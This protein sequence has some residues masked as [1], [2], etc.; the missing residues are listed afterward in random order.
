M[1]EA[2][3]GKNITH[4]QKLLNEQELR[5]FRS[6]FGIPISDK[7]ID[8]I[9]FYKPDENSTEMQYLR[10]RREKLNGSMPKR[11][12]TSVVVQPPKE[13]LFQEFLDGTKDREVSTTMAFVRILN[14]LLQHQEI[15]KTVVPIVPDEARTFGM[16]ALFRQVGIYSHTGQLYE[17]VDKENLLYYKEAKDGQILEEGITEAGSMSSFI[18]A[19]TAYSTH[20][21]NTI[22]FFIYYS[23][24]G[25]QRV[26]DL[27]WAAGDMRARGFLIGGTSGRTTLAGE[28]LQHQDGH[29]H[30]LAYPH[31]TLKAYDPAF[32]YELAVIIQDG[33]WRMYKKQEQIFYYITVMNENYP[34]PPMPDK[35]YVHDGILNGMYKYKPGKPNSGQQVQLFGS[36][37]ILNRVL[38]AQ[39]ILADQYNVKADVWSVTSYKELHYDAFQCDRWNMF[40]PDKQ[41]KTP[42]ITRTLKDADGPVIA[43]SDYVR[44]LPESISKWI[45]N[46]MLSLGTD[47]FG[48]SDGRAHLRSFFEVDEYYITYAALYMLY[49]EKKL[50]ATDLKK[51]AKELNIDPD[52][53]NPVTS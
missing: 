18:A 28:G 38:K 44:A 50:N 17:P 49:K 9:P 47:G 25:L 13:E 34:Q 46:N 45:P 48:R 8:D 35:K 52:K 21:I 7:E 1:G 6:R 22:P 10:E 27:V 39:D 43:A 2:G 3:E 15:G 14:K 20:G 33:I 37:T 31:P 16:E 51:A 19:G 26:G 4:Q 42:Y 11:R 5:H 41:E 40:H 30:L 23:M 53:A 12:T 24:F 29:S 32:A 36:G